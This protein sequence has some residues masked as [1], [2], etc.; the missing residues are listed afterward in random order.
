MCE[1]TDDGAEVAK[2]GLETYTQPLCINVKAGSRSG[3]KAH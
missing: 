2:A 1:Y 3:V